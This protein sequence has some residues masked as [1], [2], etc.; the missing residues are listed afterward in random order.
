MHKI[1]NLLVLITLLLVLLISLLFVLLNTEVVTLDFLGLFFVKQSLGILLIA[2]F[3]LGV[4]FCLSLLF[5]PSMFLDFRNKQL[6]K[7]IS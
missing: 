2:S 3:V 4:L 5:I 7:K 1:K 6:N